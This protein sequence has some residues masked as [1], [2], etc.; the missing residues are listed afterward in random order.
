MNSTQGSVTVTASSS[1][2]VLKVVECPSSGT[3]EASLNVTNVTSNPMEVTASQGTHEV[4]PAVNPENDQEGPSTAPVATAPSGA[5]GGSGVQSY[6]L[7]IDCNEQD[8]EVTISGGQGLNPATQTYTCASN[9]SA[10]WSLNLATNIETPDPNSFTLSSKDEHGNT[11]DAPT[12]VNIPID[13]QGPRVSITNGGDIIAG[14][15]ASFIIT[16]TDAN[17]GNASYTPTINQDSATLNPMVCTTNPCSLTVSGAPSGSLSL[18]V[19]ANSVTDSVSNTGP[20]SLVSS[21]LSVGAS[22]LDVDSLAMVTSANAATYTVSGNCESTQGSVT[23]TAGTPNVS[24]SVNCS[25]G[26]YTVTLNVS[27]V[28]SNPMTVSIS[29]GT[30]TIAPGVY[31]A[32]DQTPI[33][34]APNIPDQ[35]PSNGNSKSISI[36]CNEVGEVLTFSGTGLDPATQTHTCDPTTT[37]TVALTFASNT[38]TGLF[39]QHHSKQ[40]RSQWE[41][42]DK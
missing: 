8:E 34:N 24:E 25:G 36:Q 15:T 9:Q 30:N 26:K 11:A 32:N 20:S 4:S 21:T 2:Q 27:G 5:V 18:T 42:N 39:K 22:S 3:Y 23:V 14:V 28:N 31:P 17:F 13:T 41:F 12:T 6:G 7:V 10:P 35:S 19:A 29:Q 38:E 37:I 33:A 40:C 1:P 16:V